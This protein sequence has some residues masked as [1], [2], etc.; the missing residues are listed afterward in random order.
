MK[1]AMKESIAEVKNELKTELKAKLLYWN[2]LKSRK[3]KVAV[4]VLG[5]GI[6]ALKIFTTV[7][8]F[9]WLSGLFT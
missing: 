4:I 9:D 6:I 2:N 7:L 8:T 5:L 1:A 3:I